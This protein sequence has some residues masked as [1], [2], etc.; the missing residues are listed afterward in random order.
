MK[1]GN[2]IQYRM[3]EKNKV[4]ADEHKYKINKSTEETV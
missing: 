1:E 3:S 2:E 4:F